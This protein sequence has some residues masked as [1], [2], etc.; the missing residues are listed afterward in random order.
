MITQ[1][2]RT[3]TRLLLDK[4]GRTEEQ[5]HAAIDWCQD[6]GFWHSKV[7]SMPKLRDKYDQLRLEAI[8]ERER[9]NGNGSAKPR[10]DY[11]RGGAS[12]PLDNEDYSPGGIKI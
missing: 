7:M 11:S 10:R 5:I 3:E 4:D 2:W 8:A 1:E 12:D 6:S 9:Q